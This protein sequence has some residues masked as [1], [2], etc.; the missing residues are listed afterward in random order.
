[1]TWQALVGFGNTRT[2]LI[3]YYVLETRVPRALVSQFEVH[4]LD[5]MRAVYVPEALLP[6]LN[7]QSMISEITAIPYENA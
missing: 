2:V 5:A 1:M 7:R 6:R 3:P 4:T